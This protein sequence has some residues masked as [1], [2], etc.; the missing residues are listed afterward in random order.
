MKKTTEVGDRLLEVLL[1]LEWPAEKIRAEAATIY[2]QIGGKANEAAFVSEIQRA[3]SAP[4]VRDPFAFALAKIRKG[5]DPPCKA[6]TPSP[7]PLVTVAPDGSLLFDGKP[8][9]CH[10]SA[11]PSAASNT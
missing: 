6:L 3:R 5:V 1:D 11:V 9:A 8:G 7:Y 2:Q 4:S 10:T